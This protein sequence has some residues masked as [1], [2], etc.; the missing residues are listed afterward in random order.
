MN[1][2]AFRERRGVVSVGLSACLAAAFALAGCRTA[3]LDYGQ[4]ETRPGDGLVTHRGEPFD[5]VAVRRAAD[6]SLV[7]RTAYRAGLRHG[8]AERWYSDGT[9][10]FRATYRQ[11]RRHGTAATWWEDGKARSVSR[12]V[13]GVAHGVQ[14]EWYRSGAPFKEVRLVNGREEGLQRAWRENG[15]LYAN[16]EAR[17]GR[18]YGLRRSKLCFELT[19]E[20]VGEGYGARTTGGAP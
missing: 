5:G 11:G 20:D 14:R 9:A 17:D 6:G 12:H 1:P 19:R 3:E 7:E 16:Y 18:T 4:L 8:L 13:D 2:G 15:K 10:S